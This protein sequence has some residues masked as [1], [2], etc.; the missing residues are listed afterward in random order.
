MSPIARCRSSLVHFPLF[1]AL[2][3]LLAM[4]LRFLRLGAIPLLPDE[5]YYWLWSQRL[6]PAYFDNAA[7]VAWLIRASTLIGGAS[8]WGVRWLNAALGAAAV[9]LSYLIGARLFGR[10]AGLLAAL[11]IALGAPYLVTSRF[12]YTDAVQLFLLLLNLYL[13]LPLFGQ[14][15]LTGG[16]AAFYSRLILMPKLRFLTV[17]LSMAALLN[18]KYNAYLYA[19]AILVVLLLWRRD[20]LLDLR[21]WAVFGLTLLGALPVL[22]WNAA[23]DWASFRWQWAHFVA[24]ETV[25]LGSLLGNLRHTWV[26]IT[27]PLILLALPGLVMWRADKTHPLVAHRLLLIAGVVLVVPIL[28]SP[29][30]SPRN[31][32][33]GLALLLILGAGWIDLIL[34]GRPAFVSWGASLALVIVVGLYGAGTIAGTWAP[35]AWPRSSV[36]DII[37]ADSLGWRNTEA[38]GLNVDMPVFA[39]DYGIA[40]QLSYYLG[41]S[42]Y[43]SWGQYRLWGIPAFDEVQIVSLTFV[44]P[45]FITVRLTQAFAWVD[46]PRAVDLQGRAETKAVW[47]WRAGGRRIDMETFLDRFD[48]LALVQAAP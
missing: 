24:G 29:A 48:F 47:M 26:Y 33:N 44:D 45:D 18:T 23:H 6:A 1:P 38:I 22:G 35:T 37:R 46:G 8:E 7:G 34:Q 3:V 43:T 16:R 42:V 10:R 14:P 5:A 36:A 25:T 13:L 17:G 9:G 2:L 4:F 12:V 30:N 32:V 11:F 20:L 39:L 21:T 19:G 31:L 15:A 27:P 40:A 41:R 28:L